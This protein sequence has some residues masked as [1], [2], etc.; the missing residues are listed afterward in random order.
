MKNGC[1]IPTRMALCATLLAAA[2]HVHGQALERDVRYPSGDLTL[3]ALLLAPPGPGPHPAA[4]II[5][6]SGDSDRTNQWSRDIADMLV[7]HGLAVLLTDKRGTGASEGD[8]RTAGFDEL[9]DDALAGVAFLGSRPDIDPERVGLVGLSQGGWIVPVAAARGDVAFVVDVSGTSVSFAEQSFHE[10]ANTTRRAG[11]GEE[12][13]AGVLELNRAAGDYLLTG[14]WDAYRAAR[15]RGLETPWKEIAAGFPAE[16]D[17]TIWT[18]LRKVFPFEPALYWLQVAAP[19]FVAYGAE[20]ERDNV[21]VAESVRRLEFVFQTVGKTDYEILVV[22]GVGHGIRLEEHPHPLAPTFTEA[23]GRWLKERALRNGDRVDAPRPLAGSGSGWR[24]ETIDLRVELEPDG[25]LMTVRGSA[26]LRLIAESSLGPTLLLRRNDGESQGSNIEFESL[27]PE[28]GDVTSLNEAV[29]ERPGLISASIRLPEPFERGRTLDIAFVIRAEGV[30]NQFAVHPEYVTASWTSAWYPVPAPG[31]GE[32]FGSG[33]IATRG[34]LTFDLPAGWRAVS[35]GDLSERTEEG[36]RATEVWVVDEPLALGFAAGP[37]THRVVRAGER[38]VAVYRLSAEGAAVDAQARALNRVIDAM[39]EKFGEYPYAR[40]SIAEAPDP[41]P[42]F[43]AAS[44]QGFILAKP[45]VFAAHDGNLPLFAH[46]AAHA[47]W[48]N[49]VGTSGAGGIFLSESLSQYG[50]VVA[51]EAIEGDEAATRFLRF[52]RPEYIQGQCARGYF[53]VIRDGEDRPISEIDEGGGINHTIADAKG[54]WVH[55]MLRR[56]VGDSVYFGTLRDL[57]ERFRDREM[58]LADFRKAF[59]SAAP[60]ARLE[61]FFEQWLD[62]TGAPVLDLDWSAAGPDTIE[63]RIA[64][65][66]AGEPYELD[67]EIEMVGVGPPRLET[68][69][70]DRRE[71][72]VRLESPFRTNVVRLDPD[73]RVLRWTPEYGSRP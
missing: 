29:P 37:F 10:M 7:G 41:V 18:F 67:L 11:F 3:A 45:T 33:V 12:A 66:Q 43:W 42:G 60:D 40:F 14:D 62:R 72:T 32:S 24:Y 35:S 54:H 9:A 17:A 15:D 19:V 47:W 2:P 8:W 65:R 5:Q 28:V 70:I 63:V 69:T 38:S 30:R 25:R 56:R 13:V 53:Q 4:V 57:A 46:E 52:S 27:E 61:R 1:G 49:L 26:T 23:L 36:D 71:Q 22:P 59:V 39:A 31:E 68:V 16:R 21:P 51:I 50:A 64:Q 73:H 48:G 44:E 20:D 58:T 34:R 6:G 55:H